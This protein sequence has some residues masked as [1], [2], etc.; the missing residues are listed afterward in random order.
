MREVFD[1]HKYGE[2]VKTL[3]SKVSITDEVSLHFHVKEKADY[4]SFTTSVCQLTPVNAQMRALHFRIEMHR[5]QCA[6]EKIQHHFTRMSVR[7]V[8]SCIPCLLC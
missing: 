2:R 7:G 8:A 6:D 3:V 5:Y 1:I 4:F